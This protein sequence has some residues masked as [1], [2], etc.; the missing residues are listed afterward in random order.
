MAIQPYTI[1]RGKGGDTEFRCSH[2][3]Y[4]VKTK[5]FARRN[6]NVRT[7]AATAMSRHKAA[8]HKHPVLTWAMRSAGAERVLTTDFP[9]L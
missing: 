7:Q 4:C 1:R 5:D 9:R 3:D 8:E 6:G 2:C